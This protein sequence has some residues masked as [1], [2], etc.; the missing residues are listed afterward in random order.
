MRKLNIIAFAILAAGISQTVLAA[1]PSAS[2][3][4]AAPSVKNKWYA[5]VTALYIQPNLGGNN[6]GYSSFGNYG[7]DINNRVV[8]RNGG[9]NDLSDISSDRTW[10]FQ[11]NAGYEFCAGNDIDLNWYHLYDRTNG[12]LPTGS[13]FAGSASALYAGELDLQTRWDAVNLEVGQRF[14]FNVGNMI[15][16]HAGLSYARIRNTV[17]NYPKLTPLGN[18]LFITHDTITYTGFGPRIGGDYLYQ[19]GFGLGIFAKAGASILVGTAKQS[20][21]GYHDLGGFNLYSTGNYNQ[22]N[23]SI[24]V[25]VLDAN[26]GLKYDYTFRQGVLGFNLGYMFATYL[27]AIVGQ[28]GAG[29]VSS[30][31]STSTT[32]NFNVNGPYF[33]ITWTGF[34]C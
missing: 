12:S 25:P 19:T 1:Q 28:V 13:L 7:T 15:R 30:S 3:S 33:G 23:N 24:V 16:L 17:I 26:L 29:I 6:L 34:I 2:F 4:V 22:S 18:P 21:S 10:G 31:I 9:A 20:V 14:N 32:S 11:F 8:E 5:G 27:N